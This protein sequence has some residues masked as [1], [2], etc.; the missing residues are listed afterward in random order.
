M[1]YSE[2]FSKK[3]ILLLA[4]VIVGIIAATEVYVNS[5][6]ILLGLNPENSVAIADVSYP[7]Q[8]YRGQN[9][10]ITIH[11]SNIGNAKDVLVEVASMDSPTMSSQIRLDSS[12]SNTTIY[13]PLKTEGTR[14][15]NVKVSW[16]GPGGYCKI[17]QNATDETFE[18]LAAD[19]DC[20]P[21]AVV[22]SRAESFGWTLS[23][24]NTGNTPADLTIQ[25]SQKDPLILSDGSGGTAQ[26]SN[27]E[28]GETRS[29]TFHFDVPHDASLG[30]HAITVSLTTTY[31]D[32]PYYKDCKEVTYQSFNYN[33]QESTIKTQIDNA[34][35][36]IAAVLAIGGGGTVITL[37]MGKR[38][39]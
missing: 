1:N 13:L 3:R 37:I 6:N 32:T 5:P 36:I 34:G 35:Y 27:I 22:A 12:T 7:Q 15:F 17:E 29:V 31:P 4:I 24:T 14:S 11:L 16:T 38:R 39:R 9:L 26:I 33:I 18:V 23:I 19:Y 8:A 25:L 28:A 30:D 21:S 2:V 10:P 20:S